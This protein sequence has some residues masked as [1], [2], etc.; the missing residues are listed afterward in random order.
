M[1]KKKRNQQKDHGTVL[2]TE[3]AKISEQ[4]NP[5]MSFR[6]IFACGI[7]VTECSKIVDPIFFL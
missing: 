1:Y 2:S 5:Y 6:L 3:G 4:I 7:S